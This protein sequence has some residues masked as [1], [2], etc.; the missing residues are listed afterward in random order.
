MAEQKQTFASKYYDRWAKS[1]ET[2]LRLRLWFWRL[3]GKTRENVLLEDGKAIYDLGCGTGNLLRNIHEKYPNAVLYGSDVSE[4]MISKASEKFQGIGEDRVC[5]KIAD[6]NERFPW[7]DA[8]FDYVIT[9]YCFH[10][11]KE[12]EKTLQEVLRILKPGGTFYLADLC[13]P[14]VINWMVN[15]IYPRI[16]RWKDHIKFMRRKKIRQALISAGF[17]GVCQ[18]RISLFAVFS[19]GIKS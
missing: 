16:L 11:S 1:Y 7:D 19:T 13:Y 14:P 6:M 8:M 15:V 18:K 3:L 2:G 10:H 9:T 4:G 12:P 17:T 5:L